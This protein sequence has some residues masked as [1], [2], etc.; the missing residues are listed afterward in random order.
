MKRLL[1]IL[2]VCFCSVGVA[3]NIDQ[4]MYSGNKHYAKGNYK[5]AAAEYQQAY[6]AKKKP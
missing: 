5:E 3:Q 1:V 4:H 2:L 6:A